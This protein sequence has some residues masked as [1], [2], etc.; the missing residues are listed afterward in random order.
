LQ[1]KNCKPHSITFMKSRILLPHFL[2]YLLVNYLIGLLFFFIFRAVLFFLNVSLPEVGNEKLAIIFKSF[3]I[4]VQYDTV[5]SG[6][7]LSLPA[8]VLIFTASS[9]NS[10]RFYKIVG[11]YIFTLMFFAFFIC[12]ADIPF[13]QYNSTRLSAIIFNWAADAGVI[14]KMIIEEFSYIIYFFIFLLIYTVYL[15]LVGY[16]TK[17][18]IKK[19]TTGPMNRPNLQR[20]I[21]SSLICIFLVFMAVRGRID[22]PIKI[23]HSF[24]CNNSFYNQLGLNPVFTFFKSLESRHNLNIIKEDIAAQNVK[25]YLNISDTSISGSPIARN[26][27]SQFQP[28]KMN[29]VLV[30]MESM[31]AAKMGYYGNTNQLT[32]FLD[33][34]SKT[35]FCFENIYTA[36]RHTYNGIFSTVYSFPAILS[37][38]AMSATDIKHFSGFPGILKPEGYKTLYFTTHNENFDNVGVFLPANHFEQIISEK[39]YDQSKIQGT[40]GVADH[41]MFDYAVTKFDGISK[42]NVPFFA[43]IMTTSDHGPYIIPKG[44]DFKPKNKEIEKQIVEYSDWSLKR[45]FK[46]ASQKKWFKN[47]LFIFVADHGASLGKKVY[48]IQLSFHHTPLII[49]SSDTTIVKPAVY[50]G[51]GCQ[52]DI[53]PTVMDMLN[54]SYINNTLG[55]DLLKEKRPYSYFSDDDKIGCIDDDFLYVYRVGGKESLYKY[56]SSDTKDYFA[57][58]PKIA[59]DMR[60]YSISMTITAKWMIENNKTGVEKIKPLK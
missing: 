60:N 2:K 56:K 22:S 33:S 29:I 3:L 39:D 23:S 46:Q 6:Y 25:S 35:S 7:I 40:F 20:H 36:G 31:S 12:A 57:D 9:G 45:L 11:I 52:M 41:V 55:I 10:L 50:K 32:P 13:Y 4:G 34:L 21:A 1:S 27:A 59:M 19:V 17:R 14:L 54:F 28:T 38:H 15:M 8:L 47:T 44:I 26:I 37:E 49:Y 5:V 42:Q 16:F 51:Y 43:T 18:T 30:I 48:D 53:F 24:F 58:F